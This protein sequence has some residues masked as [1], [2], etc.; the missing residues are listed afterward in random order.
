[1]SVY[2]ESSAVLAWLLEESGAQIRRLLAAQDV[3]ASD[4]PSEH[5]GVNQVLV[6][7]KSLACLLR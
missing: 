3:I 2:A 6:S 7:M 4:Q 1:V 5:L